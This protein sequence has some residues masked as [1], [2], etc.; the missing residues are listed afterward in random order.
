MSGWIWKWRLTISIPD[1]LLYSFPD[2]VSNSDFNKSLDFEMINKL[3]PMWSFNDAGVLIMFK[4]I[5][6]ANLHVAEDVK[7]TLEI[8][9]W[10]IRFMFGY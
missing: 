8:V 7:A 4:Q 3:P 1:K 5:K 10:S 9:F 6:A 2:G